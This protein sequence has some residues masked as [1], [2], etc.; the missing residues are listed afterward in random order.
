MVAGLVA[1]PP[2]GTPAAADLAR[3]AAVFPT[4]PAASRAAVLAMVDAL[5]AGADA[6]GGR[7]AAVAAAG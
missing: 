5:A 3:L 1:G 6:D 4:L 7:P 2:P